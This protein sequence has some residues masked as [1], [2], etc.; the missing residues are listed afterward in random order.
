M[1]V[2]PI[3]PTSTDKPTGSLEELFRHHMAEAAVPPRPMLWEQIDNSLLQQQNEQYRRRLNAMRWVAAASLLLATLT[4][5]GWLA[6][7]D[8]VR[9]GNR[10]ATA[11]SRRAELAPASAARPG[12]V[13]GQYSATGSRGSLAAGGAAAESSDHAAYTQQ[14]ASPGRQELTAAASAAARQQPG[15]AAY[16][17][18][19]T[20]ARPTAA[21][22]AGSSSSTASTA[23][24]YQADAGS[25]AGKPVRATYNG[26]SAPGS[27]AFS[28]PVS[29]AAAETSAA[30]SAAASAARAVRSIG[31]GQ[32]QAAQGSMLA[33]GA[34]GTTAKGSAAA[35]TGFAATTGF[36]SGASSAGQ[37][38]GPIDLLAGRAPSLPNA[39]AT[40]LP[41]AF[42]TIA[43]PADDT[44]PVVPPARKWNFAATY[45]A[46][47]FNPNTNFSRAGIDAEFDYNPALGANSAALSEEAAAE[48]LQNLCPGASHRLAVRATNRL[49]GRWALSTGA[50]LSQSYAKSSSSMAFVGEQVP[51]FG[52][53]TKGAMR[54]TDFRYRT[55]G[56]PVEVRYAD[57]VKRGWSGYGR[58]GAVVSAL[59][60]VRSTV[61]GI[62]EASRSYS[63]TS[64]GTPY[65]RVMANVR[66]AAGAQY[67]SPEGSWTFSLGPIAELGVLS[68]NAHPAQGLLEQSRPYS[69]GVEAG[70]EFGR[71]PK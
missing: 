61:D 18:I 64:A 15:M 4:G 62:P 8:A 32:P 69:V 36:V 45:T 29:G 28:S 37:A 50:E 56:I 5:T 67:R 9:N 34:A 13:P 3:D 63:I 43:V 70:V 25:S 6:M 21:R 30:A 14:A 20:P 41:A 11:Q 10:L 51:D 44:P 1:S 65:R 27:V 60:G 54:T 12:T 42:A 48:H 19:G 52:P 68:L 57:P 40:S 47:T 31:L 71:S 59:L 46:G 55:A 35:P 66:G 7:R 26:T 39:E 16:G 53:D 58:V 23:S 49:G 24:T 38:L 33:F 2:N 17:G 22:Q